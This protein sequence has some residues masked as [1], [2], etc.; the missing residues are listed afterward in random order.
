[1]TLGVAVEELLAGLATHVAPAHI[2]SLQVS[3]EAD[4]DGEPILIVRIV[5]DPAHPAPSSETMF[6]ATAIARQF[7]SSRGEHRFPLLS[8]VSV[9]DIREAAA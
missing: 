3:E 6:S 8:F 5:Y 4:S 1:M 9:D 2:V 7:L